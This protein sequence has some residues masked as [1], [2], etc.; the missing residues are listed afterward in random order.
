MSQGIF[1]VLFIHLL[2]TTIFKTS[3]TVKFPFNVF[4]KASGFVLEVSNK[5]FTCIKGQKTVL[6][7]EASTSAIVHTVKTVSIF[8]IS[9]CASDGETLEELVI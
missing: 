2:P 9:Q 1:V 8:T 3:K 7:P 4:L 5:R 6:A